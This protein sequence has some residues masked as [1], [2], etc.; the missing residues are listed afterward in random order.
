MLSNMKTII[1]GLVALL[2]FFIGSLVYVGYTYYHKGYDTRKGEEKQITV[3]GFDT[4]QVV[5]TARLNWYPKSAIDSILKKH[6]AEIARIK[7]IDSLR[8]KDSLHIVNKIYSYPVYEADTMFTLAKT[9][10]KGNNVRVRAVVKQRF[11]PLQ[12]VFASKFTLNSVIFTAAPPDTI[13]VSPKYPKDH[14][15][16]TAGIKNKFD[17]DLHG[18]VGMEYYPLSFHYFQFFV[19]GEGDYNYTKKLWDGETKIGIKIKF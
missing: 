7:W 5:Q 16:I 9:D 14:V 13:K 2:V 12:E 8:I 10:A 19:G 18:F 11:L 15:G 4:A 3:S 6:P 17:K 1:I